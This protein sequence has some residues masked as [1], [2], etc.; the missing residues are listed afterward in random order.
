MDSPD[1]AAE[2]VRKGAT[3]LSRRSLPNY[4]LT[5][6]QYMAAIGPLIPGAWYSLGQT[7]RKSPTLAFVLPPG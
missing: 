5:P 6:D 3:V 2:L 4:L 1:V 7:L